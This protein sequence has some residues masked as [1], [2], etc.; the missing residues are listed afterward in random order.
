MKECRKWSLVWF[1][2][3][4]HRAAVAAGGG[5]CPRGAPPVAE[6]QGPAWLLGSFF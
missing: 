1:Q 3:A 4:A 2:T 5:I 6:L